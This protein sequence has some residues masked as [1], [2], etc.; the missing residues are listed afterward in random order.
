MKRI[1]LAAVLASLASPAFAFN[2]DFYHTDEDR[3][4]AHDT[5]TRAEQIF[6][7]L[8]TDN[9]G[10]LN[11]REQQSLGEKSYRVDK[12]KDEQI[13]LAELSHDLSV[14]S[15]QNWNDWGYSN[16]AAKEQRTVR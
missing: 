9:N 6:S 16:Q 5:R 11:V 10:V 4:A 14:N 1:V 7:R 3:R 15:A 2:W 12:N 13:T 8:D